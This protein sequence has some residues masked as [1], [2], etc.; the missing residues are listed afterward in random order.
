[1]DANAGKITVMTEFDE[2]GNTKS[3]KTLRNTPRSISR[4]AVLRG[5][6]TAM[7]AILTLQ[8][9]AALAR[10]SNLITA[11]SPDTTDALGRT[12]CLDLNSV[13]YTS[14]S[15]TAFDLG[16]PP[17]PATVNILEP[18]DYRVEPNRSAEKISAGVACERGG[19]IYY[20]PEG[21]GPWARIDL[22]QYPRSGVVVSSGSMTSMA[23][24]VIETLL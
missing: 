2:H 3:T 5:G 7:P 9:G 16:E 14:E 10:S 21:G 11:S 23:D 24:H 19:P 4:R 12:M 6:V 18:R 1:M 15:G 17:S 20:K 8:S 22:P 13:E